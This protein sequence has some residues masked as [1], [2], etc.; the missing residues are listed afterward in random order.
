MNVSIKLNA[1]TPS[2]SFE[3]AVTK[4][5]DAGGGESLD[6][7]V[8]RILSGANVSPTDKARVLKVKKALEDGSIKREEKAYSKAGVLKKL[9]MAEVKR[10]NT[11]LEDEEAR[12]TLIQMK[13][14]IPDNYILVNSFDKLSEVVVSVKVENDITIDIYSTGNE[15]NH[16]DIVGYD[17]SSVSKDIH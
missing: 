14:D 15:L 2:S 13:K 3:E 11:K 16:A 4:H 12:Q 10:L 8:K 1:S 6:Q 17:V 5:I 7:A 9:T